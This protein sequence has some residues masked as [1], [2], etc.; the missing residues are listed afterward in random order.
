MEAGNSPPGA[1]QMGRRDKLLWSAELHFFRIN[2][3][4]LSNSFCNL[5]KIND[6]YTTSKSSNM[7]QMKKRL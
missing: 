4:I 6:E 5:R 2:F 3:F 7:H 1:K